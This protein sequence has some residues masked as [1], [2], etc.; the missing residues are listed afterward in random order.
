MTAE[1]EARVWDILEKSTVGM[2][3][4]H[5]AQGLRAR[6]LDARPDRNAGVIQFVT[7]VRG[8]KD[9]EIE[10]D[11]RVCFTV[12]DTGENAY[13]SITGRASVTDDN[14]TAAKIWKK[15][16]DVWWPDGPR[17]R[18]VRVLTIEPIKAELWDGP[19]SKLVAAYEFAKARLTGTKPDLG[20]NRKATVPL[21]NEAARR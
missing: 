5:G 15:T 14:I 19:A 16:D 6:P 20:E 4:T 17:D 7:D 11:A 18:N 1:S 13:L 12:I 2:L 10:A 3:T 8:I 9:D 21:K